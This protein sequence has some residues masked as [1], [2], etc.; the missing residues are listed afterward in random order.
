MY[1]RD[2][3]YKVYQWESGELADGAGTILVQNNQREL[4]DFVNYNTRYWWPGEPDGQGPSLELHDTTLENMVA[5]NWR[6]SYCD[7]GTPGKANNSVLIS[8]IYINEFLASNNAVNADEYNDYDDWIEIYNSTDKP[9][10]IG[11]L[12]ITDNLEDPFKYQIPSYNSEKTTIPAGEFILLWADG[13][14]NQGILHLNF[15]LDQ[16]GEE[17]GLVQ[18]IDG[19]AVFIDSLSYGDQA[20]DISFGRYTDGSDNWHAMSEPTP[21]E[22]NIWT[23]IQEKDQYHND[24]ML[25]QNYPNPFHSRTVI[26]YHLPVPGDVELNI[27]DLSGRKV[28]TVVKGTQLAGIH[29]VEWNAG[30]LQQG[31]YFGELKYKQGRQ[32]IKMI[33]ID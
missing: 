11:G 16:A 3:G 30:G 18:I 9:V 15:K 24:F 10:N 21:L 6:S 4:I 8:G 7:G 22:S 12:Y 32:V 5:S 26:A 23:Y 28:V 19:E 31:I 1:T 2:Q 17:I 20:M 25:Y 14:V 33:L 13:E 29:K 27:Y